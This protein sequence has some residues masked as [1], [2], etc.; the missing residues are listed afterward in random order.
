MKRGYTIICM[1]I[2][3][4]AAGIQACQNEVSYKVVRE[5]VIKAHDGLMA[6]EDK[7]MNIKMTLD[8]L[9]LEGLTKIK[10]E[11]PNID[12]AKI[13]QDIKVLSNKLTDASAQMS[14]WME[15]FKPDMEGKSNAEAVAYFE[16]EKIKVRKLDSLYKAV[17]QESGAYLKKF[18]IHPNTAKHEHSMHM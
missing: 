9:A 17:L 7:V 8:T 4:V 12:T 6:D 11:R 5:E 13:N 18:D 2:A 1:L 16:Q 14:A 3:M 15:Y 10:A